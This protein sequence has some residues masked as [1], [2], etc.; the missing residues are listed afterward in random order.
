M[1]LEMVREVV[2]KRCPFA[3]QAG[4]R[5]VSMDSDTVELAMEETPENLNAFGLV[6]AGAICG[7]A[8]TVAGMALFRHLDPSRVLILNT[9]LNIRFTHPPRGRLS[10]AVRVLP[11]EARALMEE[12]EK[13][14]KA[15]KAIDV[16]VFD[17][18]GNM[19]AQAQA[20]FRLVKPF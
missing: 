17:A 5:V 9:I 20:T 1:E 14:G 8:E 16:K 11:E 15:D 6:H 2:E 13:N 12:F 10:S 19:V 4:M 3:A 18:K 7:M